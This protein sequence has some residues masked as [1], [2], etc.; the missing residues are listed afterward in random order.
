MA[1]V[2]NSNPPWISRNPKRKTALPKKETTNVDVDVAD[3]I[4]SSNKIPSSLTPFLGWTKMTSCCVRPRKRRRV[5][6]ANNNEPLV[7]VSGRAI[8]FLH[9]PN[10]ENNKDNDEEQDNGGDTGSNKPWFQGRFFPSF[11]I[12]SNNNINNNQDNDHNSRVS[13]TSVVSGQHLLPPSSS[14][15]SWGLLAVQNAVEDECL[16][17]DCGGYRELDL[18]I[19]RNKPASSRNIGR[20]SNTNSNKLR[21]VINDIEATGG[22]MMRLTTDPYSGLATL[23]MD[24]NGMV[25]DPKTLLEG[26]KAIQF[27][28]KYFP[29][30]VKRLQIQNL[31]NEEGTGASSSTTDDAMVIIGDMTI[32]ASQSFVHPQH[33]TMTGADADEDGLWND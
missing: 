30:L 12:S 33:V 14:M 19:I 4:N 27:A 8:F 24:E 11:G 23:P 18:T 15:N 1:E 29:S 26:D 7:R 28:S 9:D 20:N 2:K 32:I 22:N 3:D 13:P 10:S 16:L 31:M 6:N 21:W 25:F 5:Q 17:D